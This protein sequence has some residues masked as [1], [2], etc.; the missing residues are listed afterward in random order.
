MNKTLATLCLPLVLAVS[1]TACG[2]NDTQNTD[3]GASVAVAPSN[4]PSAPAASA[5]AAGAPSGAAGRRAVAPTPTA[6]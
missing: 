4:Q 6:E 3:G 1:L 5:P 2:D